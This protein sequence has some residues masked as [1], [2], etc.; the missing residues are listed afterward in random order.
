MTT[1]KPGRETETNATNTSS[2]NNDTE[3]AAVAA[4]IE[5]PYHVKNKQVVVPAS[6]GEDSPHHQETIA[7]SSGPRTTRVAGTGR[8]ELENTDL[9]SACNQPASFVSKGGPGNGTPCPAAAV[10]VD[11]DG[12]D[13][14]HDAEDVDPMIVQECMSDMA[15]SERLLSHLKDISLPFEPTIQEHLM[16][17]FTDPLEN[18]LRR[19]KEDVFSI[20]GNEHTLK[21]FDELFRDVDQVNGKGHGREFGLMS[22]LHDDLYLDRIFMLL[23]EKKKYW[24]KILLRLPDS[25]EL[26]LN[27]RTQFKNYLQVTGGDG[28][29]AKERSTISSYLEQVEPPAFCIGKKE[30]IELL[31]KAYNCQYFLYPVLVLQS[32]FC[33]QGGWRFGKSPYN[34]I[35]ESQYSLV[36]QGRLPVVVFV[37]SRS[38]PGGTEDSHYI[39]TADLLLPPPNDRG[40]G[41]QLHTS[42]SAFYSLDAQQNYIPCHELIHVYDQSVPEQHSLRFPPLPDRANPDKLACNEERQLEDHHFANSLSLERAIITALLNPCG[43]ITFDIMDPALETICQGMSNGMKKHFRL[44][45]STLPENRVSTGGAPSLFQVSNMLYLYSRMLR[46][47]IVILSPPSDEH[48]VFLRAPPPWPL[49]KLAQPHPVSSIDTRRRAPFQIPCRTSHQTWLQNRYL[50]WYTTPTKLLGWQL[51]PAPSRQKYII[52]RT[53]KRRP[54]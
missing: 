54:L 21:D 9:E 25:H 10:R 29:S 34:R 45:R 27:R 19:K 3:E 48:G 17:R 4:L 35:G 1:S 41:K 53:K 46:R 26:I 37:H 40:P 38:P 32:S 51:V 30:R 14:Y 33:L 7:G 49:W 2:N 16:P 12:F 23:V 24:S 47:R 28:P 13:P 43:G 11:P 50:H 20:E 5:N 36:N 8:T 18:Y 44:Y 15:Q 6:A 39:S 31:L 52:R 42:S 22:F